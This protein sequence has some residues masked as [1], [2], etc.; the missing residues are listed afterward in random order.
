MDISKL[1]QQYLIVRVNGARDLE[2]IE[3]LRLL[4]NELETGIKALYDDDAASIVAFLFSK[5]KFDEESAQAWIDKAREAG[6]P[7]AQK[8]K[9]GVAFSPR[10]VLGKDKVIVA[11]IEELTFDQIRTMLVNALESGDATIDGEPRWPWLIDVYP[12]HCVV[13][14]QGRF[15]DAP[16]TRNEDGEIEF[17]EWT[18]VLRVY[19]PASRSGA[20]N[21]AA[22]VF[23][24]SLKNPD[25]TFR[26][27]V[28]ADGDDD[29]LI[30]KEI[31]RVSATFRPD[32]GAMLIVT[33]DMV[34][35][36]YESFM[37][38][39]LDRV[40]VTATSHFHRDGGLVPVTE[41][42][43]FVERVMLVDGSL[44]AGLRILDDDI[45]DKIEKGLIA[46]CSIYAVPDW[47]DARTGKRWDWA[48][49]HL[50]LTNY[51][52]IT[53]MKSFGEKPADMAASRLARHYTEVKNMGENKQRA[54]ET[55][56]E[57]SA[58]ERTILEKARAL[59]AQGISLD[60]IQEQ[61][62]ALRRKARDLEVTEIVAALEGRAQ[63][64]DVVQV[65]GYRHYPAVIAAAESLLRDGVGFEAV[66]QDGKSAVD[67]M[68]IKLL[69]ALPAEARMAVSQPERPSRE[70][71]PAQV[72]PPKVERGADGHLSREQ[73]MAM[74]D[75][76]FDAY[77]NSIRV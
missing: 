33:E 73:L 9:D 28:N 4:D 6:I 69:N 2:A 18:E 52:Q 8:A 46:D 37:G 17:G 59:A 58:E 27:E 42:I 77:I 66:S 34:Q 19:I 74:S 29:G 7:A 23:N 15:Y 50:L 14:F 68:V 48:L 60:N 47:V 53:D 26:A 71:T 10:F 30:W 13:E 65:E 12:E 11:A 5:A 72:Q 67:Q 56:N 63:R 31:F 45:R 38:G 16:Y 3:S 51:P 22:Q 76:D 55:P 39:A 35:A 62:V 36:L 75:E 40:P 57:I 41:T 24:L 70:A 49:L 21:G 32:T 43:G 61:A 20:E 44:Y 1:E 64:E 25:D 54:Q